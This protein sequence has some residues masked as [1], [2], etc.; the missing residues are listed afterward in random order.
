MDNFTER[1]EQL[2]EKVRQ[3]S[4]I[5][6]AF[7]NCVIDLKTPKDEQKVDLVLLRDLMKGIN[8]FIDYI[9]MKAQYEW[10]FAQSSSGQSSKVVNES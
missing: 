9:K 5:K 1:S 10:H 6:N 3:Y 4:H 7:W 2:L 8:T